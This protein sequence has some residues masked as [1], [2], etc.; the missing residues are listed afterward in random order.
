[1]TFKVVRFSDFLNHI[2]Q[3]DDTSHIAESGRV[4][5]GVGEPGLGAKVDE[6]LGESALFEKGDA[7][8]GCQARRFHHP[9]ENLDNV[10]LE[11]VVPRVVGE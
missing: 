8:F 10:K 6:A 11:E 9:L 7:F 1:M 3:F 4:F 2:S 5:G